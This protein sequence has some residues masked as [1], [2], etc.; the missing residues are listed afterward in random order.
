MGEATVL[1]Q[2]VDYNTLNARQKEVHNFHH[3]AALLAKYGYATYLIRDDWNGGDMIARHMM[4]SAQPTLTIQIKSRL[5]FDKKYKGKQLWMCFPF[6]EEDPQLR[7]VIFLFPYDEVFAG[8]EEFRKAK[9]LP[10]L[11]STDVWI[12]DGRYSWDSPSKDLLKMLQP[13]KLE[14]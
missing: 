14:P 3:I 13:Y 10:P 12:K 1:F 6:R 9:G 2:K 5:T 4:D 8:Y 7:D 11:E